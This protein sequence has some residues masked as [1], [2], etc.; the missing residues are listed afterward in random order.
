MNEFLYEAEKQKILSIKTAKGL[1]EEVRRTKGRLKY[2]HYTVKGD[3][4]L[5]EEI[6][7]R[8]KLFT[9]ALKQFYAK[10]VRKLPDLFE[11]A[12]DK[13]QQ[14]YLETLLKKDSPTPIQFQTYEELLDVF[15][16]DNHIILFA[17]WSYC[18][19]PALH[20]IVLNNPIP[21][22]ITWNDRLT[23]FDRHSLGSTLPN[24]QKYLIKAVR[25]K[26]TLSPNKPSTIL[27]RYLADCKKAI[28]ATEISATD[29]PLTSKTLLTQQLE[30]VTT[31]QQML[32][33]MQ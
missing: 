32:Q 33:D 29:L 24:S 15:E 17:G 19:I 1:E 4:K 28:S 10:S 26:Q 8:Y 21:F 16:F 2:S 23:D 25:Y 3:V 31:V 6:K 9:L 30:A 20:Q 22:D 13:Q 7:Y 12:R 11:Q 27:D 14:H 18:Y 5:Y